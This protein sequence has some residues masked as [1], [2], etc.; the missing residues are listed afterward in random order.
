MA[1]ARKGMTVA[2]LDRLAG[3]LAHAGARVSVST[4][5]AYQAD[6]RAFAEAE[7]D[8]A[9][10]ALV[11]SD[12]QAQAAEHLARW[13]R[14]QIDAGLAPATVRRH[15]ASLGA[16]MEAAR[17]LGMIRWR[18][19]V[20]VPR[21]PPGS[22]RSPAP[23]DACVEVG[24][25]L[26]MRAASDPRAARDA[27]I[28]WLALHSALRR[29]EISSA[30]RGVDL[31]LHEVEPAI[32]VTRKGHAAPS[33]VPI[34]RSARDAIAAYLEHEPGERGALWRGVRGPGRPSRALGPASI[35]RIITARAAEHGLRVR[36]HD[37]RRVALTRAMRVSHDPD[38]V[39]RLAGHRSLATTTAYLGSELGDVARL[40]DAL[41]SGPGQLVLPG[42]AE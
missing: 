27:A 32:R 19:R 37:L 17:E 12:G 10:L 16:I 13:V 30:K 20:K 2:A 15:I 31:D 23:W 14:A 7:G 39:R 9:A 29:A 38:L 35:G 3:A 36:A 8:A 26:E 11:D 42:T 40:V 22:G 1:G 6:F 18:V 4:R 24:L 34:S 33:W 21:V 5:R 25:G 41:D 28:W